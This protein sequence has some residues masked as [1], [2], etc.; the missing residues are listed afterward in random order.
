M[1]RAGSEYDHLSCLRQLT[2]G[3]I[4]ARGQLDRWGV[5]SVRGSRLSGLEASRDYHPV[6]DKSAVLP[7]DQDLS[8]FIR[9]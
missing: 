6:S 7:L 1:S 5:P 2:E 9:R 4:R 3:S 8:T